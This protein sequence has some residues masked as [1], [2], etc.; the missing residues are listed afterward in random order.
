MTLNKHGS[1]YIRN[2]WPTKI[3]DAIIRNPHIFSPNNELLAVD[4]IGV[5]RVMIKAMRYWACVM[6]IAVEGK[7]QIGIVHTL[8]EIANYVHEYDPYCTDIGTLWLFHRNLSRDVDNATAWNW[9]FNIYDA[10]SF[11]KED[12]STS[13]YA[14]IQR[15]GGAYA[16]KMIEK[17]FDCFKNTYVSDQAFSISKIIDEDTVPFFAPLKLIEYK[18]S[19][20]FEKRR[21]HSKD[22]PLDIF[23]VCILL[24]NQEHLNGNRQ[25][26]IDLLLEGDNQAGKYMNLSYSTLLEL[27]QQ[28]EN[29]NYIRLVNNF[30]N[31][32]IEVHDHSATE[33]LQAHYHTIG[34]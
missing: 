20:R 6:G 7:D 24:D 5:G 15:E 28:L 14:F 17:E 9:A 19:G 25:I 4:S 13:L 22:V 34:R 33:I 12:F 26:G 31:R 1:F 21:T 11:T 27:L 16:K 3:M 18:G 10:P 29:K 30:G 2:G 23:F 8:T 32:Y